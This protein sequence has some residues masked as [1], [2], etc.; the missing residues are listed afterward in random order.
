MKKILLSITL[1]LGLLLPTNAFAQDIKIV[2]NNQEVYPDVSPFIENGRTMVPVRFIGEALGMKV[3]YE[4]AR[5]DFSIIGEPHDMMTVLTTANG[6]KI[7]IDDFGIEC[8]DGITFTTDPF[9]VKNNRTFVPIRFISNALNMDINW[10]PTT[11]LIELKDS[12]EN[13]PIPIYFSKDSYNSEGSY[14]SEDSYNPDF[15]ENKELF[16]SD[17]L[18]IEYK[19]GHYLINGKNITLSDV[20][21][22][23]ENEFYDNNYFLNIYKDLYNGLDLGE[24][25]YFDNNYFI[26]SPNK[27]KVWGITAR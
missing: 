27:D 12:T 2:V 5:L 15:L 20:G 21:E 8:T 3:T 10:N 4:I 22:A 14:N 11:K 17:K 13:K 16:K 1:L 6:R 23:R 9:I 25:F 26:M 24:Y 18:F 7:F 19:N